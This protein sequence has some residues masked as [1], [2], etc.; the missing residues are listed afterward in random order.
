MTRKVVGAVSIVFLL[1]TG[2]AVF[3]GGKA[4]TKTTAEP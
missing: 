3:A 2:G 1:L 4:E